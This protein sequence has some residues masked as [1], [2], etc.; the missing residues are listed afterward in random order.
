MKA[1]NRAPWLIISSILLSVCPG[2]A[3]PTDL[4]PVQNEER[5]LSDL[6]GAAASGDFGAT[7][8]EAISDA[9]SLITTFVS[10][11]QQLE[12]ATNENDLVDLLGV[13]LNGEAEDDAASV[14]NNTVGAVGANATCPGMAVLFARGTA[15][16]GN[17]GL[18]AGPPFF[19]ALRN[20]INGSTTLAVQGIPYPA[21]IPGFLA[22]GSVFGSGVMAL[23]VNKTAAAC[24]NTKI[25]LAGY[26]Q[27]AQVLHNAMQYINNG[28]S[29]SGANNTAAPFADR[30][31]AINSRVSS[32]VLF[33]DP[34]NGTAVTGVDGARTI[35]FCS[36][37]DDICAKGGDIITLAHLTYSQNA[38]QAAM[39]VMQK[40]GLGLASQDA[41]NQG[42]GNV[43][44]VQPAKGMNGAMQIGTGA[45]LPGLGSG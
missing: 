4:V 44:T 33:G 16:I 28:T 6:L 35:S 43:P 7:V 13:D 41:V 9:T 10:A 19:T 34:R 27:G 31:T 1:S 24:P 40:S 5:G 25:V 14:T 17:V 23:M 37:E 20:Y 11:V 8:A 15:E 39:F 21:S 2:L 30:A 26:S 32:V 36:A 45:G 38:T 22:G 3:Q 42:M 12:N 18:F 29:L